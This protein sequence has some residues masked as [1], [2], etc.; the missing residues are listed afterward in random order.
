AVT[1]IERQAYLGGRVGVWETHLATGERHWMERGFHA[2]FRQYYNLR[3]LIRRF[4]PTLSRLR[5]LE[6]YLIIHPDGAVESFRGLPTTPL[7]NVAALVKRTEHLSLRDLARVDV[8][9]AMEMI[10]FDPVKTY[11]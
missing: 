8:A 5:P 3:A 1:L 2:F 10:A 11:A 6:D 4:D 9:S 7:V